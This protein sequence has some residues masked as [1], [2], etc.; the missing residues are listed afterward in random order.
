MHTLVWLLIHVMGS[1]LR[2]GY[3]NFFPEPVHCKDNALSVMIELLNILSTITNLYVS[4]PAP[5]P[6]TL[7]EYFEFG[8]GTGFL[9]F[10]HIYQ[11][12]RM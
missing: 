8:K 7:I 5:P 1:K 4:P 9:I 12:F 6:P 2:F 10:V 11:C 3:R